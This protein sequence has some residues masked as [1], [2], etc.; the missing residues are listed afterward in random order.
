MVLWLKRRVGNPRQSRSSANEHG[1]TPRRMGTV[2]SWGLRAMCGSKGFAS[3]GSTL[4]IQTASDAW[5]WEQ[6]S[7]RS[8]QT[9]SEP[10]NGSLIRYKQST[11]THVKKGMSRVYRLTQPASNLYTQYLRRILT[12]PSLFDQWGRKNWGEIFKRSPPA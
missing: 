1:T 3:A 7:W 12:L 4:W 6:S 10:R 8:H 5:G 2:S 9:S 11:H